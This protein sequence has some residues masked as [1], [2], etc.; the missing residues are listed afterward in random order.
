MISV[1]I[2]THNPNPVFFK[3]VLLALKQQDYPHEKWELVVVDNA[4]EQPVSNQFD[5]SW[6]PNTR[7]V[8][9]S[10]LGVA[11]ARYRAC[12]EA[13]GTWFVYVDDD[14]VLSRNYLSTAANII[15]K[16]PYMGCFGGKQIGRF[17]DGEPAKEIKPYLSLIAVRDVP[18]ARISNLYA[19][20]T[21][22]AGA[23]MIIRAS[24]V[25]EY[26][27]QVNQNPIRKSLGRRGASLMSSEDIDIA[28]TA[29]DMGYMS[30]LFPELTME[31]IIPGKRL[32]LTYLL[33]LK[34]YNIYSSC[35]LDYIRFRYT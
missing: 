19:W 33:Q 9:E 16:R 26:V 4:S 32:T 5:F 12:I 17:I 31:H 25:W 34:F 10:N 2:C 20:E 24:V 23:G 28:Y 8:I 7:L 35:M 27:A 30:G 3:E 18:R 14:N 29:L 15:E 22:P 13:K 1:L 11:H 6:H 21:T